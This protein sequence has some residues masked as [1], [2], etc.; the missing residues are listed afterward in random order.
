M[1]VTESPARVRARLDAIA[2]RRPPR[3]A[4]EATASVSRKIWLLLELVR[5]KRVLFSHYESLHGRD[6][7]TFQRDLQ[8]LRS[9]GKKSGFEI[10]QIKDRSRVEL[11]GFDGRPRTVDGGGPVLRLLAELADAMGEPVA[12]ELGPLLS[13]KPGA[14]EFLTF[15]VPHLIEKSRVGEIYERLKTAHGGGAAPQSLVRFRYPERGKPRGAERLVEPYRVLLRSGSCYLIGYDRDRRAWRT[16]ALDRF[17]SV[18]Q[19]A[20]T[21]HKARAIPEPYNAGDVIG[22]IKHEGKP[23]EVIVELSP[24]VAQAAVSRRWQAAQRSET[25]AGGAVRMSFIVS[26]PAEVVRWSLGFGPEARVVGPPSAVEL[27]KAT[28]LAISKTYQ[29]PS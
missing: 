19:R 9:I 13:E 3:A 22:F 27:A 28:A 15:A 18:P 29:E 25:L 1:L 5:A 17:L 2:P 16:F 4:S 26:D 24:I 7:R 21:L 20:G 10:S 23:H 11:L 6:F 8:Q 14:T 12:R